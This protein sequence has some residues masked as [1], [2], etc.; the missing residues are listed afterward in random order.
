MLNKST[1]ALPRVSQNENPIG[2]LRKGQERLKSRLVTSV[3]H[4]SVQWP[5]GYGKSIGLALAFSH[6]VKQGRVNRL[7]IVVANDRQRV[8]MCNDF[9]VD[10]LNWGGIDVGTPWKYTSE[11]NTQR[12]NMLGSN[13]VFVTTIQQVSADARGYNL[14]S[15]MMSTNEWMLAA[16]EYHHYAQE[17][18]WG[19]SLKQLVDRAEFTFAT[20][21]TPDRDGK[22]TIFAKPDLMV[23]YS[24]AV[25][26]GAVKT[27]LMSDYEYRIDAIGT[28]NEL[29][30]FTTTE[31]REEAIKH[32][33]LTNYE[34][35][36]KL[37][38]SAKYI[39]P[40]ISEPLQ[41]LYKD[42]CKTGLPLQ[43]LIRAMSCQHA[44]M[45]CEQIHA[46]DNCLSVDWIGTG[47]DG[48]T[49]EQNRKA[50]DRFCPGKSKDGTRP[51]PEL[52]VLVQVGMA[53]EGF[54]T[55]LVTE[56]VDLAVVNLLGAS[57]QTRQFYFRGTRYLGEGIH[58]HVNVPTDHP[59]AAYGRNA[60]MGFLEGD[61]LT[62]LP[63]K[64]EDDPKDGTWEW[65]E[66][67]DEL[68]EEE[69]DDINLINIS[70]DSVEKYKQA[71]AEV[72]NVDVGLIDDNTALEIYK[73]V[74]T[75]VGGQ[76]Q[77]D[78]TLTEWRSDIS[79]L[80]GR[81]AWRIVKM[82]SSVE[83]EKGR[84]GDTKRRI[85]STVK[86]LYGARD[87]LI[88]DELQDVYRYLHGLDQELA[89]GVI[90]KWL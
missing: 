67:D 87:Q 72:L 59:L 33:T 81:I 46:L 45:L 69:F 41:R 13:C 25:D 40:L 44:K 65:P 1:T 6:W 49:D 60:I 63:E 84:L 64:N 12:A 56:I 35:K 89:D 5:G 85:R 2:K 37:R 90:P 39:M 28:D 48:R 21:A 30:Q 83:F 74:N 53:G 73:R 19:E 50:C 61:E 9:G 57:N 79:K 78:M 10:A 27:V 22:S 34:K 82:R 58:L 29:F 18:D 47:D 51:N 7:L 24:D 66:L 71:A 88:G 43:C 16:D 17:Q 4:L 42:R 70:A 20:S 86:K 80:E 52:D 26:E 68:Y 32:D 31:L 8:Q 76:N 36:K 11:P 62:L 54:D 75:L 38:Y 55:T 15:Q 3:D 14:M 23:K 77:K